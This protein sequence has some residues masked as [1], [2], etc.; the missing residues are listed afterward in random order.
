MSAPNYKDGDVTLFDCDFNPPEIPDSSIT[1]ADVVVGMTIPA[2]MG[3]AVVT[4]IDDTD[5]RFSTKPVRRLHLRDVVNPE[6][7]YTRMLSPD[8]VM[9]VSGDAKFRRW[10]VKLTS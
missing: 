2:E 1:V 3:Y 4:A 6:Y 10:L 7:S 8:A 9:R 5:W